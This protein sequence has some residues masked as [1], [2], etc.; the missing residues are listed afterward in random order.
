M[1]NNLFYGA[2]NVSQAKLGKVIHIPAVSKTDETLKL[3]GPSPF[4]EMLN[5][6]MKRAVLESLTFDNLKTAFDVFNSDFKKES[7]K[8]GVSINSLIDEINSEVGKWNVRFDVSVNPIKPEEI[9]KNLLSHHIEDVD[10]GGEQINLASFGQGLQRHLIFTLIKLSAKYT[11]T[12]N[13]K[14]KGF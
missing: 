1:S 6:V 13:S 2:K 4:R 10:L 3:S 7:S 8:E 5:L 11:V 14:E 9:V 12:I